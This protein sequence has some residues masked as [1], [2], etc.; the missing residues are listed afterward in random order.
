[1]GKYRELVSKAMEKGKAE[2][3]W[4]IARQHDGASQKEAS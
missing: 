2:E 3:A 1:M 4:E